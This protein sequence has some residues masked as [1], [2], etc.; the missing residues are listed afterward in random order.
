MDN[1][2]LLIL[3]LIIM[4]VL[5]LNYIDGLADSLVIAMERLAR[6]RIAIAMTTGAQLLTY[7][8]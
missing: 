2:N 8:S 6:I 7:D 4:D 1:R 5:H 3:N